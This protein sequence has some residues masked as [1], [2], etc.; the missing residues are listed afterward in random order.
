MSKEI[1]KRD[2]TF[3]NESK[4]IE[5]KEELRK[6]L[7]ENLDLMRDIAGKMID[8]GFYYT[9]PDERSYYSDKRRHE[10]LYS[11]VDAMTECLVKQL[12]KIELKH[13]IQKIW[14]KYKIEYTIAHEEKPKKLEHS[15]GIT[16]MNPNRL[17]YVIGGK[18]DIYRGRRCE[19]VRGWREVSKFGA[20]GISNNYNY[21]Y[22]VRFADNSEM[23][24][25]QDCVEYAR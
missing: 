16:R 22:L 3:L 17:D 14:D 23:V 13:G 25:D 5:L 19:I 20:M 10:I 21:V 4:Q 1:I 8:G 9:L 7:S 24:V 15:S 2:Y 12:H 6:Y 11:Q 18:A